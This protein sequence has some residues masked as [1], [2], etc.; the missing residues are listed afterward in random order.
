MTPRLLL[1]ENLAARLVGLLQNEFPGSL[2][3]RDAIRPAATDAE[4]W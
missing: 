4:V 1:D 2:H 3:V